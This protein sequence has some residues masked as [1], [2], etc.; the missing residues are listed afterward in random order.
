MVTLPYILILYP[1]QSHEK[2][3][4]DDSSNK[5]SKFAFWK[6]IQ[7]HLIAQAHSDSRYDCHIAGITLW[8]R[9]HWK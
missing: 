2:D 4:K 5:T 6:S 9:Y 1:N 8:Y 7:R 3:E